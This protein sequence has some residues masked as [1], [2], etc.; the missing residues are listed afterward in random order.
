MRLPTLPSIDLTQRTAFQAHLDD[1]TKPLGALGGL[2][3][4]GLRLAL[5]AGTCRP[6]DPPAFLLT[7][8]GDHGITRHGVS[9]YPAEV[10]PQ[11]VANLAAGGAA[12]SVLCRL[13]RITHRV[14][15]VGVAAPCDFPG[16]I[17]RN[18]VR[19]TA[20]PLQ[21]PA[22]IRAEA[23]ACLQAG[24]DE[25]ASLPE[26]A[27]AL[28]A[29]GEMGIGNSAVAA[30][31]CCALGGLSPEAAV[32]PGTGVQGEA[33]A[34]KVRVVAQVLAHHAPDAKDPLGV[35][36][37]IG[38]AEFGAMAGA[39]LGAASRG[40]A[41]VVD[42]YIAGAAALV[43]LRL[44]PKLEDFLV[45]SHRSAEPGASRLMERLGAEPVLDLGLRLGEGSGAALAVP[46]LRAA[47]AVMR[48]MATFSGAGVSTALEPEASNAD[49]S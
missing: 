49:A 39:M 37:A 5:I 34:Q 28:L 11:M 8:A 30:L 1:L 15:D 9:A 7:F 48:E 13:N 38:G 14:V 12:S 33:L 31:L 27:F 35:L 19:G 47:C 4:L 46:I 21:G 2:E 20:D 45:W 44:D 32:G 36:A 41:V 40:W 17:Q 43:A 6:Q 22:M 10:T 16:V 23:E 24:L 29:V 25:V 42:G 26:H 3:R 18:V